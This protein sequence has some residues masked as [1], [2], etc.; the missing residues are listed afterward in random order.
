MATRVSRIHGGT[1][2]INVYELNESDIT[3]SELKVKDFGD[4]T[5]PAWAK[6]VKINRDRRFFEISS[7][8]CNL[9]NKYDIVI[10]P[11]ADD[12]M[13]LFFRQYENGMISFENML[14]GMI[15]KK[16]TNQYSFH[17]ERA[18]RMLRKIEAI[19]CD[20]TGTDD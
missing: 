9:D 6:F 2:V 12:N 16:T 7:F 18:I 8:D 11:I 10:G 3:A 15:Y 5:S 19:A 4:T 14:L 1:P 17:T 20:D 13:A